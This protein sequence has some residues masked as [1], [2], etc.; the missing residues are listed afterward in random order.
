MVP[1]RKGGGK[2]L[3]DLGEWGLLGLLRPLLER[4][5]AG[6]P[7][8]TGDDV[9]V[10]PPPRRDEQLVWTID[11]MVEGTH[12]RFWDHPAATAEALGWKLAA[13]NVS[14]LAS[15]GSTPRYGL[16]S[17]GV[18][19]VTPVAWLEGFYHGLEQAAAEWEF[20][21]AGGDT[22]LAPQWALTLALV[23]TLPAGGILAGR[24]EA[25]PGD[26]LYTT[27]TPGEAAAGL[28]ILE[29]NLRL[30]EG[31]HAEAL[32]LRALRP[33]PRLDF[34]RLLV[35]RSTRLAMIDVSDGVAK[36]AAHVAAR[37]DVQM[38]LR[39]E[40]LPV[41]PAL[42]AAARASGKPAADFVLHG[43]EDYELLF[44]SPMEKN[45]LQALAEQC[46]VRLTCIG[47]VEKGEGVTLQAADGTRRAIQ[48][49][50]Y[51]HFQ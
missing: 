28:E 45:R 9:A 4:Q 1:D 41:S 42:D 38:L 43:G 34:G 23:G 24:H 32:V 39:E 17:V 3:A 44:A 5:T 19:K 37:S 26:R 10:T 11:S 27:G 36:D 31:D 50:G 48:R 33:E 22:V 30:E 7:L 29:G 47:A 6:F 16:L 13:S 2:T 35:E 18:P 25:Q 20:K 8:P 46:G 49:E 40:A 15:K 21:L 14:D 51:E 12:F